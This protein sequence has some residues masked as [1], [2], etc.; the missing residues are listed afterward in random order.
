MA[1]VVVVG[2]GLSGLIAARTLIAGDKDLSLH[3]AEARGRVGGRMLRQEAVPDTGTWVDVGGQWAGQ[4]HDKLKLLAEHYGV[5]IYEQYT[6][7]ATRLS[8]KSSE[9]FDAVEEDGI[10]GPDK[11]SIEGAQAAEAELNSITIDAAEPWKSDPALDRLTFAEWLETKPAYAQFYVAWNSRFNQSGGSPREVSLLHTL[12]ELNVNPFAEKPDESLFSGGAGQIPGRLLTDLMDLGAQFHPN[13]KVVALDQDSHKVT[14]TILNTLEATVSKLEA[15]YAVVA[16]PPYLTSS[17]SFSPALPGRRLQLVQR[18]PMGVLAKICCVYKE[19]WWRGKGW[20]GTALGDEKTFVQQVADS[21]PVG[22]TPGYGIL[23]AFI[24]GEQYL[25]W[26]MLNEQERKDAVI[27]DLVYFFG[28]RADTE[29]WGD[30]VIKDWPAEPLTGGAYNAYLPPGGWTL[31]GSEIRKPHGRIHWAGTETAE[32]WY[33]Y[34][35]GAIT[36]GERAASEIH[37]KI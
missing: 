35:E 2:A 28:P 22:A 4:T 37:R 7:G 8:Y 20:S 18:M 12:F 15:D 9:A 6:K 13:S 34:F 23:A 33:G 16:I 3:I 36:A 27:R 10:P 14:V 11:P 31:Y 21:G 5:G 26:S 24:Q 19:P 29:R 1:R 25:K 32:R 30:P 17:I